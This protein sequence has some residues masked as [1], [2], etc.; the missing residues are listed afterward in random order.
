MVEIKQNIS[1]HIYLVVVILADQYG[2]VY[3]RE[4]NLKR[5]IYVHWWTGNITFS[6]NKLNFCNVFMLSSFRRQIEYWASYRLC[7]NWIK[8]NS[9]MG[10]KNVGRFSF[11]ELTQ[12]TSYL[13]IK[14]SLNCYVKCD[15][16]SL[17]NNGGWHR[18]WLSA[19]NLN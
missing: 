5:G 17:Q 16:I 11:I 4:L 15:M 18:S 12:P 8:W 9:W 3:E 2:T 1:M 13:Q 14:W 10:Y 7:V 19:I 6:F